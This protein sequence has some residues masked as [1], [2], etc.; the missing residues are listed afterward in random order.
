MALLA[1]LSLGSALV[2]GH[3][4]A[5]VLVVLPFAAPQVAEAT[6][7]AASQL[8][9]ELPGSGII[10]GAT[11]RRMLHFT[12]DD[13]PTYENTPRLLDDL[14][15][16]GIKATF[17]FSTSRFASRERRNAHAVELA[18]EVARRGHQLGAHGFDHVHMARLKP[19]ALRNELS[20]S[21]AM[22]QQ[23]FGARTRWFRPP[24]GSRN[25]AL[26]NMLREGSYQTVMWNVGLADWVAHDPDELRKIFWRVLLR[27]ERLDGERGGVVL[28][29]DSHDWSVQAF[30]RIVDSIAA[31]NCQL[32]Q[33]GEELYDVV[34]S[35]EPWITPLTDEA[36]ASR[37]FALRERAAARCGSREAVA[38]PDAAV[39]ASESE[40]AH[41]AALAS[42]L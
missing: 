35:L 10:T 33:Q 7:P 29:H 18:R 27:N 40:A 42:P 8:G 11:P 23:A 36:Y 5:C 21:E 6:G 4:S 22:F 26:D 24:Y 25:R 2:H 9:P 17:F 31:R 28:L 14:D 3:A 20:S 34:D 32:L 13:G 38:A 19:P 16:A 41:P 12:F 30:E 15:R 39:T 1:L 37:Q